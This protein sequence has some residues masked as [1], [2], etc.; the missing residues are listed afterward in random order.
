MRDKGVHER[1]RLTQT[2]VRWTRSSQRLQQ[3]IARAVGEGSRVAL[4]IAAQLDEAFGC[5]AQA[6]RCRMA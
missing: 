2:L 1:H 3:F 5:A 6:S 4:A